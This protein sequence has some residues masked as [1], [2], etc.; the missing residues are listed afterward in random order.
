MAVVLENISSS[1]IVARTTISA[2]Y[3]TA[4]LITSVP[5]VLYH[6]KASISYF[7]LRMVF[8]CPSLFNCLI[9]WVTF[10][11]FQA[12]P[13]A[14]FHQLLLA[15]A[16]PDRETQI[17]AHSIF[18]MVLMPS[19]VSPWLDPKKISKKVESDGLSIQHESLSGADPLNGKL[20]EE[21]VKAGLSGK[22]FFTHA[23]ADGKDVRF[24]FSLCTVCT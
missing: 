18:S 23:L 19:V 15:M 17:G 11:L 5:N 10:G 14:L 1:T 9:F 16:H 12:F 3:Q 2:V 21:K 7:R 22:K 8:A 6:N 4:K 13:D 20:V 24:F